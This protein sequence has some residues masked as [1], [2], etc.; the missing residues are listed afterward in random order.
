[1]CGGL[2][3]GRMLELHIRKFR[4]NL[5]GRL[6][7]AEGGGENDLAA[8]ARQA[9][10]GAFG[11]GFRDIF[12]EDGLDLVA[13]FLLN[14]LAALI[15]LVGPA[16]IADRADIDPAGLDAS[17]SEAVGPS[18]SATAAIAAVINNFFMFC[19]PVIPFILRLCST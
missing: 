1:M 19:L 13:Q 4:R 15:M 16:E 14:R 18:P 3:A 12:D 5:Q 6:H 2:V 9:L 7:E 8:I 10:D 11:I 17:A